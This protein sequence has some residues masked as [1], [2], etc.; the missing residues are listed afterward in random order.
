MGKGIR[1]SAKVKVRT[2]I[3]VNVK[4]KGQDD[5]TCQIK[6]DGIWSGWDGN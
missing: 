2:V 3:Q 1:E 5:D 4:T 6:D